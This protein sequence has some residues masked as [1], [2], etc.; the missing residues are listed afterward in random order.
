M[1]GLA[2]GLA[3]ALAAGFAAALLVAGFAAAFF[4]AGAATGLAVA[5]V[6]G[7]A[8]A[9]FA[10]GFA[11]AFTA[12]FAAVFTAGFAAGFA[13]AFATGFATALTGAVFWGALTAFAVLVFFT[14]SAFLAAGFFAVAM[15]YLLDGHGGKEHCR[16]GCWSVMIHD[17]AFA[18]ASKCNVMNGGG[19]QRRRWAAGVCLRCWCG[20]VGC[21]LQGA[22]EMWGEQTTCG[23]CKP[24]AVV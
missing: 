1:A 23:L 22:R 14:G 13:T 11:G 18:F 21:A 8:A 10:A 12:A 2:A 19:G 17:I 6:A 4:A 24:D 15:E 16:R 3:T 20:C 7:F 9:A 5:L